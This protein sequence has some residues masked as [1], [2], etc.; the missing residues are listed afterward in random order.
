MLDRLWIHREQGCWHGINAVAH[1]NHVEG[2]AKRHASPQHRTLATSELYAASTCRILPSMTVSFSLFAL[3]QIPLKDMQAVSQLLSVKSSIESYFA[4]MNIG[5]A[6][7]IGLLF[8]LR[9]V[10]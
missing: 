5:F 7:T 4:V 3:A 10:G 2:I 6:S 9:H 8:N 1:P